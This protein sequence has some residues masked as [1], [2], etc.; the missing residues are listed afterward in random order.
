[1]SKEAG[2]DKREIPGELTVILEMIQEDQSAR[3][4]EHFEKL[5]WEKFVQFAMHHKLYPLLC[6]NMPEGIPEQS[7]EKMQSHYKWNVF[8]ML[9][10]CGEM[11]LVNQLFMQN[12]IKMIVLKGPVLGE[13]LYGD[14][15]LRTSSDLDVLIPMENLGQAEGIL[16]KLGYQKDDYILTVLNDWKW[17]HHHI[18]FIHPEKNIKIELH[19]RLNPGPAKEPSFVDLWARRRKSTLSI[20]EIYILGKE[21]L[22]LFLTTH[23]ARHGWSRLRWLADIDMLARQNINWE[24]TIELMDKYSYKHIGGQALLLSANFFYTPILK[25]MEPFFRGNRP[26]KLAKDT[27]FYLKKMVSLHNEPLPPDVAS[28]H[29]KYLISIMSVHQKILHILSLLYPFYTDVETLPLPRILHVLYFPL[30]PFLCAWRKT[31]KQALF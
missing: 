9:K 11:D 31:R 14:I 10:L 8:N 5:D 21:D 28:Y 6:K 3:K 20:S 4:L 12:S 27:L 24:N 22:F 18:T 17:R 1:M 15:S 23:G 2:L 16:E 13:D 29:K 7:A 19:W 26:G 25:E 30:R